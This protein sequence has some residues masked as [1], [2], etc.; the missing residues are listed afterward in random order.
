MN[1]PSSKQLRLVGQRFSRSAKQYD[2]HAR[3]QQHVMQRAFIKADQLFSDTDHILDI[4][5]GTGNFARYARSQHKG[6]DLSAIDIAQGMCT[7]STPYYHEVTCADMA[8]MPFADASYDGI[9]SSLAIQW[10]PDLDGACREMHRTL[11]FGGHGIITTF[12]D[13]TLNELREASARAGMKTVMPMH[14]SGFYTDAF[15]RAG[16]QVIATERWQEV[17][18]VPAVETLMAH[19]RAIGATNAKPAAARGLSG[20]KAFAHMLSH[21]EQL[22]YQPRGL[23]V[24][25]DIAIFVVEKPYD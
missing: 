22:Y 25:W 18:F 15:T 9:F 12:L 5:S 3:L 13:G 17:H 20:A 6:W 19:L 16:F 2:A 4:G 7:I 8:D 21:Y 11:R 10:A 1:T 23:P 24:T 14:D